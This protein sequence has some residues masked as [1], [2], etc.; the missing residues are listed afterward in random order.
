MPKAISSTATLVVVAPVSDARPTVDAKVDKPAAASTW[1]RG[2]GSS[3]RGKGKRSG[4]VA[5]R[6]SP[7]S[8]FRG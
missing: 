7:A 2:N 6:F 5:R 4:H 1:Q 3:R 8:R